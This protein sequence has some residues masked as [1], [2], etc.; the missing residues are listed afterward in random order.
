MEL[1]NCFF[2]LGR[3]NHLKM[4]QLL[5]NKDANT[6]NDEN[7]KTMEGKIQRTTC[8]FFTCL[9]KEHDAFRIE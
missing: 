4:V 6:N 7:D 5:L 1:K 9:S 3:G 2:H 8:S